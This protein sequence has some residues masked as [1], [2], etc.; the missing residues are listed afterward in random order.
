MC[1]D[2]S[3]LHGTL[4]SYSMMAFFFLGT[5]LAFIVLWYKKQLSFD[6]EAKYK[7]MEDEDK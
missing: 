2:G 4:L 7:M 3:G 5:L 6:E 1:L